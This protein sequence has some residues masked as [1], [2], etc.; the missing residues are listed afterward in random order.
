MLFIFR[1]PNA[2]YL[3]LDFQ[4]RD[5]M[6]A[7]VVLGKVF[8]QSLKHA[9]VTILSRPLRIMLLDHLSRVA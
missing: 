2:Q 5:D 8:Q 1:L 6:C 7:S 3:K 4:R 9:G